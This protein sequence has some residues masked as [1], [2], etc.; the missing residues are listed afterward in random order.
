MSD[1]TIDTIDITNAINATS[2]GSNQW[3]NVRH[4]LPW[5][6]WL[7]AYDGFNL[8][9]NTLFTSAIWVIYLASRGYSPLAIGLFE[10]LFHVAKLM[11][12]I[13]TGIFADLVGRRRSLVI[14]C[15]ISAVENLLFLFPTVPLLVLSFSLAGISYAFLGGANEAM[16][17]TLAGRAAQKGEGE[18][19][20]AAQQVARYSRLISRMYLVG[21]VGEIIGT[22]LGGYLGHILV[23]LPFICRSA[24]TLLG[25]LPLLLLPEHKGIAEPEKRVSPLAH[26]GKSLRAVGRMPV[27]LGLLLVSALTSSCWQTIYFYYQLYLHGLGFSLSIVGLVVAASTASGFLFTAA[28]PLIMRRLPEHWLVPLFVLMEVVGLVCMSL[29][30][31]IASLFGY[32]VLFQASVSVLTPAISTYINRRCPEEQRATVLSLNTGLFSAAMIVLFPLFGLSITSVA[33][34]TVY[35]WT[36]AALAIGCAGI[37][38]FVLL[39]RRR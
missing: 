25:I 37:V 11:F 18:I 27:L 1:A 34:S 10:M 19:S 29:P 38:A 13:P 30:Q 31:S 17:W 4:A 8:L 15:I 5:R 36:A 2:D 26:L 14:F 9:T 32:L 39:R 24:F 23:T 7:Y 22:S 16:L 20:D 35:Q 3:P 28:T 6:R 21:F 33:Y 12:E